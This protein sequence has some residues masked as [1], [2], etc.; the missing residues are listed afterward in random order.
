[1]ASQLCRRRLIME[2]WPRG[3]HR[4]S[5]AKSPGTTRDHGS[6][7]ASFTSFLSPLLIPLLDQ[8][9]VFPTRCAAEFRANQRKPAA[10]FL[11][12]EH[13]DDLPPSQ[14]LGDR[15]VL[16]EVLIERHFGPRAPGHVLTATR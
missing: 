9:P 7:S 6:G 8:Q 16:G 11:S 3:P 12:L 2:G 15:D 10:Q 13:H 14:L 1:M 4:R 5:L